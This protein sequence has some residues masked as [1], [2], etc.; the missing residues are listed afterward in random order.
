MTSTLPLSEQTVAARIERL[1]VTSWHIKMRLIVGTATFF[2]AFDAL[3]IAFIL[4]AI[5]GAWKI[6]PQQIGALIA[7]GYVGQAI[8]ALVFGWA[9]ERYGR[10]P[11]S[12]TTIAILAVMSLVCATATNYD[13]L[14]WYRFVQGIGLGGEVPVAAAY[15]NEIARADRRGRFFILYEAAFPAGILVAGLLGA[16]IVPRAGWQWM[17]YLGAVPALVALAVR[18]LCPESP[19]WLAGKGRL[20]EADEIL[21]RIENQVSRGGQVPLPPVRAIAAE[22][23]RRRAH[24]AELFQGRYLFRTLVVSALWICTY[25]VTYGVIVWLPTI[26][27]TVYHLSIQQS[28]NYSLLTNSSGIVSLVV[29]AFIIDRLG[30]KPVFTAALLLGSLPLFGL[31][32]MKGG[33]AGNVL[34]LAA[35]SAL[36]I[37]IVSAGLYLYT[38]ELYPTRI[39][40]LGTGWATFWLR[41]ASIAGPY[42]VGIILPSYG[43]SGVFLLFGVVAAVGGIICV[44]GAPETTG[45]VLEE[46]SP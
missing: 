43:L 27:R 38:P 12:I 26:F 18:R 32:L 2:D 34:I 16:W 41:V 5:I 10:I 6:A 14:F 1:P 37:Q 11:I 39:R 40:A 25:V 15:I 3:A 45:R 33:T 44:T 35:A 17:F 28:L 8:G 36:F 19:R 30:R 13:Q 46:I 21:T 4:P 31:W 24:W 9:A 7:I 29:V 20:A 22:T 23:P 42:L